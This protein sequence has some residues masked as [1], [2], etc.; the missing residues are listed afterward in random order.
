MTDGE[1]LAHAVLMFFRGDPWTPE[2]RAVWLELTDSPHATTR[3]LCDLARRV[4]A[5]DAAH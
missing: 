4:K 5:N 1:K 2:D 3:S